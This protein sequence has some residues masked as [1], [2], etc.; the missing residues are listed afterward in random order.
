M[1]KIV[2]WGRVGFAGQNNLSP[3]GRSIFSHLCQEPNICTEIYS[4]PRTSLRTNSKAKPRT[5]GLIARIL[6]LTKENTPSSKGITHQRYLD[7]HE[8]LFLGFADQDGVDGHFS[9]CSFQTS[10]E[11]SGT[12]YLQCAQKNGVKIGSPSSHLR[13]QNDEEANG[14]GRLRCQQN[15]T[16][17]AQQGTHQGRVTLVD[18]SMR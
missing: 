11:G 14:G 15:A 3:C 5:N 4:R 1:C 13:H 8:I 12:H 18:A 16:R 6:W 2:R 7:K 17:E 10:T 9:C